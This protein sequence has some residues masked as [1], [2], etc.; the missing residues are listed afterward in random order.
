MIRSLYEGFTKEDL[1]QE[2]QT[3]DRFSTDMFA[4]TN[5]DKV[6]KYINGNSNL[7]FKPGF[8]PSTAKG[9]ENENFALVHIDADL[10]A[11]TQ[12]ALNFFYPR[13]SKGGVIIVHDYNHNWDGIP[14]AINE[15]VESIPES[16]I[17]LSD[18]QGSAM[19]VKNS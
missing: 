16:L 9:L 13:L 7:R 14:K 8:F 11:P 12:E 17:E 3:E 1:S 18:W 2:N 5:V 19:I 15:F 6:K 4:N 10:Y